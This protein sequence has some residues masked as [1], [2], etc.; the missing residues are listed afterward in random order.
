M[1]R[2]GHLALDPTVRH[3]LLAASPANIDRLL[4]P[5]RGTAGRRRK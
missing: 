2:H 5:I 1:E 3:L 4:A